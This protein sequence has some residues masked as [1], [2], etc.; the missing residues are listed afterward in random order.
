MERIEEFL[1]E[2]DRLNKRLLAQ[3]DLPIKRFFALDQDVFEDG[4]IPGKYKELLGLVA[5]A[6]LRCEDCVTYHLH[7]ASQAGATHHEIEESLAIALLIGGSITVPL[8][9]RAFERLESL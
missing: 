1:A 5:S 9:R 2:R 4:A 3:A 8:L 7:R 6:V